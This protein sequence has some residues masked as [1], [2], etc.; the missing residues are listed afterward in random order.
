MKMRQEVV[1]RQT[2]VVITIG[3]SAANNAVK[4]KKISEPV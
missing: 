3:D 4:L 1:F 2:S